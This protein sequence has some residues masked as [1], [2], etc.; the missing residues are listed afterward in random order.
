MAR[1]KLGDGEKALIETRL[2]WLGLLNEILITVVG[3]AALIIF[4]FWWRPPG[5]MYWIL[6][7]AWALAC[8]R[9]LTDWLT[10]ELAVTD[11]RLIFRRGLLSKTGW[12]LPVDRV[13]DVKFSQSA[14]QRLVG[15][16]NMLVESAGASQ[17]ALTN[18]PDPVGLNKLIREA[19]DAKEAENFERSSGPRGGATRAEQLE[20]L[21]RLHGQ[22]SLTAEE[23]EAEKR[24]VLEGG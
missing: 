17:T 6:L 20:I 12:E 7:G 11:R 8:F 21:A 1:Q 4:L 14:L 9:G 5:W 3:V 19:R 24:R 15:A 16:G 22:G 10:S 23:F 18:V 13:L 2:H